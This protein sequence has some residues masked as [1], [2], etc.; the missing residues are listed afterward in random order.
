[1][2]PDIKQ[3]LLIFFQKL[4][5]AYDTLPTTFGRLWVEGLVGALDTFG[6][7]TLDPIRCVGNHNSNRQ[8][9]FPRM[10]NKFLVFTED[11][12]YK[13]EL[14]NEVDRT[15]RISDN[16]CVWDWQLQHIQDSC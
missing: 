1:M 16:A 7:P 5:R 2:R 13:D 15:L 8:P 14:G 6:D 3:F 10:H 4:R 11:I 9:A 12:S